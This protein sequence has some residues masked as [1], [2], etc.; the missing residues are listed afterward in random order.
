M[1]IVNEEI[2]GPVVVVGKF[3]TD[4]EAITYANQTDYGLGAAISLKISLLLII[5]LVI[6]KLE[7]FGLI[8]QMI[9]II[10]YHLVE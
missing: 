9:Q 7:W 3:S 5:W 1:R 8:L 2:F 4:E 10:M 6:L